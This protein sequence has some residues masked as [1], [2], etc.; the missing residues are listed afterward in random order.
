[1]QRLGLVLLN[2]LRADLME[3]LRGGEFRHQLTLSFEQRL[4]R[5]C[6]LSRLKPSWRAMV[7]AR[8]ISASVNGARRI[9]VRHELADE[10]ALCKK[11]N[12]RERAYTFRLD[13]GLEGVI[14]GFRRLSIFSMQIGW[15]FFRVAGS[16][17]SG[18]PRP[19]GSP[20]DKSA[21]GDEPHEIQIRRTGGSTRVR[22]PDASLIA[23]RAAS[24]ASAARPG[25]KQPVGKPIQR[26]DAIV[27]GNVHAVIL[28]KRDPGVDRDVWHNLCFAGRATGR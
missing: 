17:A 6:I 24:Q 16:T 13:G 5:R 20:S 21:P 14:Q 1:M 27:L 26:S 2:E 11:R 4:R 8:P 22:N 10:A 18:R 3:L 28:R 15:G 23:S 12:E 19:G 9:A 25:T 7:T